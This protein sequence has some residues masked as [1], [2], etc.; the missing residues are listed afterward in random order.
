MKSDSGIKIFTIVMMLVL[1]LCN[2]LHFGL[3]TF[4]IIIEQ[5]ETG[6]GYGTNIE[7]GAL[8]IWLFELLLIPVFIVT[9]L[10]F[11]Y[12][13]LMKVNKKKMLLNF[14]LFVL[15]LFQIFITNFFLYV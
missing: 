15:I 10:Y 11:L 5:I 4:W 6:Y 12:G 3:F 1:I 14:L 2:L 9:L 7:M 13:F 8:Y